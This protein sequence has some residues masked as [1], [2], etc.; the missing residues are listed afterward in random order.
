[1]IANAIALDLLSTGVYYAEKG[2]R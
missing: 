2:N 1:M